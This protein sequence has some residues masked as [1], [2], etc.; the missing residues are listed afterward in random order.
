M[1]IIL[2]RSNGYRSFQC[3]WKDKWVQA[4]LKYSQQLKR[5]DIKNIL[6]KM[7]VTKCSLRTK[8]YTHNN[9]I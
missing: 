5:K 9:C 7:R 4:V 8:Y 2:K 3:E 1:D 6:L